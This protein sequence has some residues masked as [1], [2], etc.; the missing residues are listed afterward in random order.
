M[1]VLVALLV[2]YLGEGEL[3][4]PLLLESEK[5]KTEDQ[6]DDAKD[7]NENG[8]AVDELLLVYEAL[9]QQKHKRRNPLDEVEQNERITLC[10][11]LRTQHLVALRVDPAILK[12][13]GKQVELGE[14]VVFFILHV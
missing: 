6:T 11:E 1:Q 4:V 8:V 7:A 2:E 3:V 13:P 5:Q 12:A 10:L 14:P 9:D